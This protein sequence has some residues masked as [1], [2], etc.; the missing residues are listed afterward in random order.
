MKSH[1]QTFP[2]S[3]L[4][5]NTIQ[6]FLTCPTWAFCLQPMTQKRFWAL[7]PLGQSWNS[8]I[9]ADSLWKDQCFKSGNTKPGYEQM[10]NTLF[11]G[12]MMAIHVTSLGQA[13]PAWLWAS[14]P[15]EASWVWIWTPEPR[16]DQQLW[17]HIQGD[18]WCL[19]AAPA[20]NFHRFFFS[21]LHSPTSSPSWALPPLCRLWSDTSE[22]QGKH[23]ALLEML[24]C[25]S[26]PAL[27]RQRTGR[28]NPS[29]AEKAL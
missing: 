20:V 25:S 29:R 21:Q 15:D 11:G 24:V 10:L 28:I 1:S 26:E 13:L 6:P 14:D 5:S 19:Q 18:F 22:L 2:G 7:V 9:E 27:L 17:L 16:Q 8:H 12:G 3:L 23:G 4:I